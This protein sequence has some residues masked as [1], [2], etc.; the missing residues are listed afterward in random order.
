MKRTF[1]ARLAAA[2]ALAVTLL[3]PGGAMAAGGS[4]EDAWR[5]LSSKRF[6]DLTHRFGPTTPVWAGFGPATFA[7]ATD[8]ASGRPYTVARDGFR[9][10][11][12]AMVGQYGTHVDPP[13][14]FSEEGA[15]LDEIPVKQMILPLE[16]IDMTAKLAADPAHALTIDDLEEWESAYGRVREGSFAA[17][18]TD[19]YRDFDSDPARFRRHPFPGWSLAAVRFLF[20]K[21][22]VTAIG[23]EALDTDATEDMRS[24]TWILKHGHW[25]IEV[26]AHLDEVPATGAL[27]VVSWPKPAHGLGFPAR[28]FAILP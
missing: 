27:L 8:P 24:E 21:R 10:T 23:H 2:L 22:H 7:A 12:F 5:I 9:S 28:A 11:F 13:A 26:M 6:V 18:R 4:L 17:L 14:H 1:E 16:V 3:P 15:T 19:L 20:E 25:Q